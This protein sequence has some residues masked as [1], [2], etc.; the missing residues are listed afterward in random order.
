MDRAHGRAAEAS[1]RLRSQASHASIALSRTTPNPTTA[2]KSPTRTSA[3]VHR[4]G[5][6]G[7][8]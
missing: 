7:M 3:P 6:I 8:E 4:E 1:H 5:C 2:A